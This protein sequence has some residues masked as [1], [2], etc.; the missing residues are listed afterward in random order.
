MKAWI[1]AVAAGALVVGVPAF[2]HHSLSA[3]NV[4]TYQTV[5]GTVK[6]FEWTNPHARLI[7]VVSDANGRMISWNLEGPS[8]GRLSSGGFKKDIIA[9]GDRI[10]VAYNPRRDSASG[11]YFIA[12]T[13]ANG[14][15]YSTDRYK[16]L[17]EAARR[18]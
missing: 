3:Y 1:G 6:S 9:S 11:G 10:K 12:V 17:N 4:S 7:L 18:P 15:V 16:Q 5:D 8:T 2:A 13:A 14:A